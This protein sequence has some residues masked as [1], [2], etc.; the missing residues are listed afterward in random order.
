MLFSMFQPKRYS[1]ILVSK[2]QK[3]KIFKIINSLILLLLVSNIYGQEYFEGEINYKIKYEPINPN[4]PTNYLE[5]ELGK[6]FTAFVKE[7]R[8]AMI[9]Q[10]TGQKGWL[11]VIVRLDQG[12]S[13][14]EF[15]RSD[16]IVKTKFGKQK[17]ELIK[18]NRNSANKKEILGELCES[19]SITYKS[20]DPESFFQMF[21]G[22]YYFDPRYKLNKN[23][24]EN[25]TDGFWSLYV[26]ESESISI[27]NETEFYPLFKA[28]QEATSITEKQ[29]P[30]SIFEIDENKV[31]TEE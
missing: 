10:A 14:T 29:I 28:V 16:T 26:E 5:T 15:E 6:T 27:R 2:N 3:M 12:Y 19:V 18:F 11:K 21:N 9:Y 7:D 4:I 30:F 31:I 13:Y 20:T 22:T 8:Y 24:Y 25:Y 17:E 23:L 1:L